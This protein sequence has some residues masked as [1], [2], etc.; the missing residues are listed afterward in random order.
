MMLPTV[1]GHPNRPHCQT[2]TLG[3]I[4][5]KGQIDGNRWILVPD[6][7][8]LAELDRKGCKLGLAVAQRSPAPP[9]LSM[10]QHLSRGNNCEQ[11]TADKSVPVNNNH[12]YNRI[13]HKTCSCHRAPEVRGSSRLPCRCFKQALKWNVPC[14]VSILIARMEHKAR[15]SR[16]RL[17]TY[18]SMA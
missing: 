10:L 7:K 17:C 13:L 15:H 1:N 16:G 9:R 5:D 8:F 14:A 4:V 6:I 18:C 12:T 3:R 11:L 2:S